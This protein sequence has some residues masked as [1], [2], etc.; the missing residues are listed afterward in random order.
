MRR[1]H[2]AAILQVG[3]TSNRGCA[4]VRPYA[5]QADG[6]TGRRLSACRRPR[7]GGRPRRVE[8]YPGRLCRSPRPRGGPRHSEGRADP[9]EHPECSP[10]SLCEGHRYGRWSSPTRRRWLRIWRRLRHLRRPIPA[11]TSSPSDHGQTAAAATTFSDRRPARTRTPWQ[12]DPHLRQAYG[13]RCE[14]ASSR[15][16]GRAGGRPRQDLGAERLFACGARKLDPAGGHLQARYSSLDS[17]SSFVYRRSTAPQHADRP[18]DIQPFTPPGRGGRVG[19]DCDVF[20]S[21][22]LH[23]GS[24]RHARPGPRRRRHQERAAVR[25][26]ELHV[27][28]CVERDAEER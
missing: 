3:I 12:P 2:D 27:P 11:W 25:P 23:H 8:D 1:V 26:R 17:S 14:R 16:F 13:T 18:T 5:R 28:L 22:P 6:S 10:E 21:E 24:E 20:L 4:R 9:L 15:T 7:L 19:A